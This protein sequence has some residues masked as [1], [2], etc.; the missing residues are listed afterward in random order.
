MAQGP[1][2]DLQG[3]CGVKELQLQEA[4]SFRDAADAAGTST[5]CRVSG[6]IIV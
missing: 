3:V 5:G 2:S 1:N 4:R 6:V